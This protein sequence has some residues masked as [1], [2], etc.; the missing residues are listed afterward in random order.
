MTLVDKI[1]T[2]DGKI[3]ANQTRYDLDKKAAKISAFSS[4]E[5]GE[6]YEYINDED[7]RYK[8]EVAEQSQFY[9]YLEDKIF[10]KGL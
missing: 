8:T 2:L 3:K 6:K 1:K 4:K 10:D 9:Y 5:L 7:F